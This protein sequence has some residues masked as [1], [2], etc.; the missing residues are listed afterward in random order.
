MPFIEAWNNLF[1]DMLIF[2]YQ[3]VWLKE[4]NVKNNFLILS[5]VQNWVVSHRWSLLTIDTSADAR[6]GL[7]LNKFLYIS[8]AL[9]GIFSCA[10]NLQHEKD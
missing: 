5:P 10:F 4:K 3:T 1:N 8:Q 7:R 9:I 6:W 2:C